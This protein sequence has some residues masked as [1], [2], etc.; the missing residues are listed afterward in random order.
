MPG[1]LTQKPQRGKGYQAVGDGTDAA[2]VPQLAELR[3]PG[4]NTAVIAALVLFM[5]IALII[6]AASGGGSAECPCLPSKVPQH[7]QTSPELWPG[8][9]ATGKAAFL[10]QTVAFEPTATYVPNEPLQTAIPIVGAKN[11]SI[12]HHM[13]YVRTRAPRE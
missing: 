11:D 9:T 5:V 13:G 7:F 1:P 2:P 3:P 12:F 6:R 8:P 10:A 4:S